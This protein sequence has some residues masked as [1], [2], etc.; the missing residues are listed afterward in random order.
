MP[1]IIN[2]NKVH[3][4]FHIFAILKFELLIGHPLENLIQE[5]PSHGGLD[6]KL[7]TIASATPILCPKNPKA[8][9]QPNHNSFKEVKFI[10]PFVSPKLAYETKR[11]SSPS[12][13]SKPCPSGQNLYA[14]DVLKAPT[15]ET[16]EKDS[17]VKHESLSFETPHTSCS[18]LKSPRF[19]LLHTLC[20][21]EDHNHP[22][23]PVS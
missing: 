18:I 5:K 13:K 3:I 6:E 17:T 15:L 22:L 1:V 8:K 14:M 16:K 4:D 21:Y 9:Q 7:G 20:F 23:I 12:L 2:K 11:A 19:V 10:S